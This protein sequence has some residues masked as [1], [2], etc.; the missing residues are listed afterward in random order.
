M[1]YAITNSWPG[2]F[3]VDL[4]IR[5]TGTTAINGWTLTWTYGGNQ[6]IYNAWGT[7]VTQS[8]QNV[9]AR[10]VDYTRVINAGQS[11]TVGMQ[12][13]V[14]GTNAIPTNFR[15]NNTTNCV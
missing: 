14:T 5:N 2:N 11:V 8:G 10:N 13:T 12:G 7:Q 3:Q 1:T 9:T 4:S 6:N 15:L